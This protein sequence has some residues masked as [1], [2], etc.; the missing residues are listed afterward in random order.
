M[1]GSGP[2]I[3]CIGFIGFIGFAVGVPP[4]IVAPAAAILG[5]RFPRARVMFGAY[6]LQAFAFAATAG[7]FMLDA[8]LLGYA[9]GIAAMALIAL[10]RPLLASILP[11]VAR[12]P[13][14]LTTANVACGFHAGDPV[15][16]LRTVRLAKKNGVVVGAHPGF[17][18]LLGFG[19]RSMKSATTL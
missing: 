19:R 16:L 12:S 1:Y 17:P 14:E 18:D 3:G 7:A 8:P 10:T 2:P 6:V 13:E 11:E 5:D 9:L 15:T 4:I